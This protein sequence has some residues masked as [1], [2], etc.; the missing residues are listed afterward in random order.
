M[1]RADIVEKKYSNKRHTSFYLSAGP[2]D[3]PVIIFLH[4]WPELSLSWRHQLPFFAGLGAPPGE[5]L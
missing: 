1:A 3:G 2:V 4:G 5:E